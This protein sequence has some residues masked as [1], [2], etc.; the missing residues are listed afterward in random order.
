MRLTLPLAVPLHVLHR[1]LSPTHTL[2]VLFAL[3]THCPTDVACLPSELWVQIFQR[4]HRD[5]FFPDKA[6]APSSATAAATSDVPA[7]EA[8]APEM[9]A[10]PPAMDSTA[11]DS[12]RD[13]ASAATA[14]ATAETSVEPPVAQRLQTARTELRDIEDALRM[15]TRVTLADPLDRAAVAGPLRNFEV[16]REALLQQVERLSTELDAARDAGPP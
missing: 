11:G 7:P 3:S 1:P 15:L 8:A 10:S 14:V 13:H 4:M 16:R 2:A 6:A 9:L 5:W 12:A